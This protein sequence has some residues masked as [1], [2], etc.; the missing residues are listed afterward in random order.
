MDTSKTLEYFNAAQFGDAIHI[1][2]CGSVGSSIAEMLA[3]VGFRNF[4]LYD[5]DEVEPHN[6]ANQM[7]TDIQIGQRK[8]EALRDLLVSINPDIAQ[9]IRLEGKWERGM[10]ISGFVFLCLDNIDI[11]RD[12]VEDN[13]FNASIRCV[14][15]C[16]TGLTKASAYGAKWS[17]RKQVEN[18]LKSMQYTHEEAMADTP[19]TA[20]GRVLGVVTT[21]RIVTTLCIANFINYLKYGTLKILI[22]ADLETFEI[23]AY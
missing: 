10:L 13:Q 6:I 15:D 22:D 23:Q 7:F 12:F 2:G 9:T 21:V 20:C 4:V 1:I 3:R 18:L 11:R 5:F 19:V 17:E 16:R 14:L 8:T